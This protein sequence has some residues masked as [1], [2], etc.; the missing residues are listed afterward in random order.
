MVSKQPTRY[1]Q[2]TKDQRDD[3]FKVLKLLH[4]PERLIA[5]KL[6]RKS[7][8]HEEDCLNTAFSPAKRK[9]TFQKDSKPSTASK[10]LRIS[11]S[12]RSKATKSSSLPPSV[13]CLRGVSLDEKSLNSS[14][15]LGSQDS[16]LSGLQDA[17]VVDSVFTSP[18]SAECSIE[19]FS[20]TS[21]PKPCL[22]PQSFLCVPFPD[23][24]IDN[25]ENA[26]DI[27]SRES[28]AVLVCLVDKMLQHE[29]WKNSEDGSSLPEF[30]DRDIDL[31]KECLK[32]VPSLLN[33]LGSHLDSR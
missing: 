11:Q 20:G 14:G 33:F 22:P 16:S 21:D 15:K 3:L 30:D 25:E 28:P 32:W 4:A 9:L 24:R 18:T 31:V 27:G 23:P 17:L 19:P 6:S 10:E 29:K 8:S 26:E 7:S 5:S 2:L 12:P 1:D 13:D